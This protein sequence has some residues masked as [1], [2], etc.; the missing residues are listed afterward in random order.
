[1]DFITQLPLTLKGHDAIFVVVDKLT[2]MVHLMPT[3]TSC[4]ARVVA[5]LYRDHVFVQHGI[6]KKIISDRDSRF[7]GAFNAELTKLLG[8]Q[9]ALSTAYHPQSDGQ[10]ER[11]NRVLED[12]LRNFVAP[13]QDD[14]DEYLACALSL[15]STMHH[16]VSLGIPLLS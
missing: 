3:T 4:S 9:Q 7:T 1:M 2:K 10:T 13:S 16:T 12:M 8:I 11:V 6:P 14:W 15:L 5:A